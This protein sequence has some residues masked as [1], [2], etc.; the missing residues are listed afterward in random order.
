MVPGTRPQQ[1][2]QKLASM[3]AASQQP[4]RTLGR[5]T[6]LQAAMPSLGGRPP[7]KERHPLPPKNTTKANPKP[8]AVSSATQLQGHLSTSGSQTQTTE[9]TTTVPT[10]PKST[11]S[12]PALSAPNPGTVPSPTKYTR[13]TAA[14]S[15]TGANPWLRSPPRGNQIS[16]AMSHPVANSDHTTPPT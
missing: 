15:M 1:K 13:L 12:S 11:T 9:T 16:S 10:T 2:K 14:R 7:P 8:N 3:T 6:R 5:V 4:L